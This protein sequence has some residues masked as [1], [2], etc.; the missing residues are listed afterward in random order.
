[1]KYLRVHKVVLH[2]PVRQQ[3]QTPNIETIHGDRHDG[4][5][6]MLVIAQETNLT[7]LPYPCNHIRY[8]LFANVFGNCFAMAYHYIN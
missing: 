5:G 2:C 8:Y 6:I 4:F 7:M 3:Y 1:M